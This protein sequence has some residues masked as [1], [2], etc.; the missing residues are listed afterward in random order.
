MPRKLTVKIRLF[1]AAALNEH[2][3]PDCAC[4]KQPL[5]GSKA[6]MRGT[7][8]VTEDQLRSLLTCARSAHAREG[9]DLQRLLHG[10]TGTGGLEAMV[11]SIPDSDQTD[12]LGDAPPITPAVTPCVR[13]GST[14]IKYK[15]ANKVKKALLFGPA[16]FAGKIPHCGAC[17]LPRDGKWTLF[18]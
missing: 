16:L 4:L 5:T 14:D 12:Y 11:R 7:F 2:G 3:V 1:D 8:P 13:C 6:H 10:D 9:V 15:R 18:G 17:G